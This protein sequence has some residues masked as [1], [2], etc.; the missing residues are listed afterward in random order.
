MLSVNYQFLDQFLDQP[1]QLFSYRVDIHNCKIII[2]RYEI[3]ALV[4]G[5]SSHGRQ[6]C[7]A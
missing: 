5:S 7:R 2:L 3:N 4:S 6:R 1:R